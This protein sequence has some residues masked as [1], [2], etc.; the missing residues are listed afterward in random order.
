[1][2]T[3]LLSSEHQSYNALATWLYGDYKKLAAL[4]EQHHSWTVAYQKNAPEAGD[5]DALWKPVERSGLK[6]ILNT[7]T[8]FPQILREIPWK[9]HALYLLG[10]PLTS[11]RKIAIV[12]T[13]KATAVGLEI[14]KRFSQKLSE[15]GL[16]I[17][18]GLA[19]GI[20]AA[21]HIGTLQAKG[22][23]LAVL[24]CGL[25]SMYPKQ[26]EQLARQILAGGGTIIS[27]YPPGSPALQQRFLERNRITSGLCD[28]V[29]VIEAPVKSG[30]KS[31]AR[32]AVEQNRE[33]FVV[34]GMITNPNYAGS[35]QLIR[36]GAQLVT[37][38]AEILEHLEIKPKN[39]QTL[40]AEGRFDKLDKKHRIILQTLM[41]NGMPLSVDELAGETQMTAAEISSIIT[42]LTLD[43][44]VNEE[45]GKYFIA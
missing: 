2:T 19:L 32:F 18:S 8:G 28:A 5:A 30:V 6:L 12:G 17:V 40:F 33:V 34:P 7:D 23:T 27:E 4:L 37:S 9:P 29:V 13:R 42:L 24:A 22:K 38:S 35:H 11:E 26:N 15:S 39:N 16:A 1:M 43:G 44:I 31:T 45:T 20:D 14:T 3:P 10:A 36:S 41:K 25:D 21:A